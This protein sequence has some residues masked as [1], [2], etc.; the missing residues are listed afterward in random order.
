MSTPTTDLPAFAGRHIGP[1]E[2]DVEQMLAVHRAGLL[3][4]A[5]PAPVVEAED[6]G[7]TARSPQVGAQ[8]SL[9]PAV[10]EGA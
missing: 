5:G 4:W 6:H 9:E 3:T 10:V 2:D 1:R 8:D 7:F